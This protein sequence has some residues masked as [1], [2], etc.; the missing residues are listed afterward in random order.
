[1][2]LMN[3]VGGIVSNRILLIDLNWKINAVA[4]LNG[5]RKSDILWYNSATGQ[6]AV[7]LMDGTNGTS[8]A[9]LLTDPISRLQ[10]IKTSSL[11]SEMGCDEAQANGAPATQ[12]MPT[13]QTPVVAAGSDQS[14]TLPSTASLSG[15]ASDDGAPIRLL[16]TKWSKVDG[17]GTVVFGN[18]TALNSSAT[19]SAAGTYN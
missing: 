17:P 7:W 11:T 16:T 1:M 10:C 5:D 4:D 14:I 9:N 15:T 2:W 6:T 13:N 8:G 3:G 19:F 12:P 18:A